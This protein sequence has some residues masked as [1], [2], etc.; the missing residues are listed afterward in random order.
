MTDIKL[1]NQTHDLIYENGDLKLTLNQS[2]S[3]AQ[4][5]KV[6]LS[7]FQGEWFLNDQLGLPYYQRIFTKGVSK[8]TVDTIYLRAISSEP[9]V[10]Q[11]LDFDSSMDNA[12]RIYSLSFKV[13]SMNDPNPIPIEIQL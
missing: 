12:N 3:L 10:I 7:T 11:V 4:R 9:E 5:L 1:D 13:R 6:K 2:E 8:A